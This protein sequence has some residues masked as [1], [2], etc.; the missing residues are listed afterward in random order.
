MRAR[1]AVQMRYCYLLE[2]GAEA[3]GLLS[4]GGVHPSSR[5]CL[6]QLESRTSSRK[7]NLGVS[8]LRQ[9]YLEPQAAR[10]D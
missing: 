2:S 3:R 10:F 7:E 4:D 8:A 6:E 9:A 1:E 5:A